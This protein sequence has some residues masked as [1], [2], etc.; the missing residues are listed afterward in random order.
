M[1]V[2]SI[3]VLAVLLVG[4]GCK[5]KDPPKPPGKVSL[6]APAKNSECS[7]VQ[8]SGNNSSVVLFVWQAGAN[9]ETYELRVTN[10]NTGTVQTKSTKS[11]S[12][13]LPL[14]KGAPFSWFVISKNSMVPET[15][16]SDTWFFFNPG[17]ETTYAP[18]PAEIL[19][20]LMGARVFKD[21]NNEVTLSW[22]GSDLDNDLEGYEVYFSLETPPTTLA[23]SPAPGETTH[24]VS[25]SSNTVYYWK[26]VTKDKEGNRSDTGILNF[27]VL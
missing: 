8:S 4:T 6:V 12:D 9:A 24:K 20:P 25:V 16:S 26:V 13:T 3:L 19:E 5:K 27:K 2:L 18:F 7:P 23:A 11:L 21:I 1:R 15:V 17:S 22:S 14:E 10:L